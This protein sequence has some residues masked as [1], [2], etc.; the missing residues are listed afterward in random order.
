LEKNIEVLVD[1]A[2]GYHIELADTLRRGLP[3]FRDIA[4]RQPESA[5]ALE[6][7]LVISHGDLDQKNVLWDDSD[8]PWL[9]DWEC[10]RWMNPTHEALMQAL[11]WSGVVGEF[12]PAV[13]KAFIAAYRQAGGH[14]DNQHL[15]AA[16]QC[17]LGDWLNWL[18]YNVGRC[19]DA[20]EPAQRDTGQKQVALSLAALQHVMDRVPGLLDLPDPLASGAA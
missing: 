10:A 12:S 8:N 13:F 9:I 5:A 18:M 4:Q 3:A 16:Y 7:H 19:M 2:E 11:N 15:G 1:F 14:I 17:V 20:D 6:A